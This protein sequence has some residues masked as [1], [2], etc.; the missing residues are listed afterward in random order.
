MFESNFSVTFEEAQNE[1][2]KHN[3]TVSFLQF[4]F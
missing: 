3:K 1:S 4:T 2:G